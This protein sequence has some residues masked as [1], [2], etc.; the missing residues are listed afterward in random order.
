MKRPQ[1]TRPRKSA[2]RANAHANVHSGRHDRDS[3]VACLNS[4]TG[5]TSASLINTLFYVLQ[6]SFLFCSGFFFSSGFFFVADFE[7]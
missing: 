3:N 7:Q 4:Q 2:V 6:I 5:C 1:F